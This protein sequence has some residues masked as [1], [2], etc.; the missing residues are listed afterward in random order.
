[1]RSLA[2]L[3]AQKIFAPLRLYRQRYI[4]RLKNTSFGCRQL[5]NKTQLRS[6]AA[7]A[8][9]SSVAVALCL[10]LPGAARPLLSAAATVLLSS[11]PPSLS[12]CS[13]PR[14]SCRH[15]TPSS[16]SPLS[17]PF[18]LLIVVLSG[19]QSR[20]YRRWC[21]RCRHACPLSSVAFVVRPRSLSPL[22][23]ADVITSPLPSQPAL[24]RHR[25]RRRFLPSPSRR[26]RRWNNARSPSSPPP[27]PPLGMT[28]TFVCASSSS[29]S[30][31]RFPPPHRSR[32]RRLPP[33]RVVLR[34]AVGDE[35]SCSP[36]RDP[37]IPRDRTRCPT[38][39]HRKPPPLPP[40]PQSTPPTADSV[41]STMPRSSE[42]F[43]R[44]AQ[45]GAIAR[46]ARRTAWWNLMLSSN[47]WSAGWGQPRD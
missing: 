40:P 17:F 28:P 44:S 9:S 8:L 14:I 43:M 24:Q 20:C 34:L 18:R 39:L 30:C 41:E 47:Y 33:S 3:P 6:A 31:R 37:E 46:A 27:P 12:S 7:P 42:T 16:P 5:I 35:T 23:M 45:T 32:E 11:P 29:S 25:R 2:L 1:M 15:P 22:P 21:R 19:G 10:P 4:L 36:R 38:S 13:S 26:R